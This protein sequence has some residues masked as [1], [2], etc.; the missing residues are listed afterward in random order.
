MLE[1][2]A[3]VLLVLVSATA[4]MGAARAVLGVLLYMM[5]LT[6]VRPQSE[7]VV[8]RTT[9][10]AARRFSLRHDAMTSHDGIA[11]FVAREAA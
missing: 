7:F 8:P 6:A 5:R 2:F 1:A 4:A 11:P 10:H 3:L 9:A